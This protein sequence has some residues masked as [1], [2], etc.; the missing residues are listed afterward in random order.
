M[1]TNYINRDELGNDLFGDGKLRL[2]Q[3]EGRTRIYSVGPDGEWNRGE[4]IQPGDAELKGDL[5]VEV[6]IGRSDIHWLAEG[7][8]LDYLQGKHTARY[9]AKKGTHYAVQFPLPGWADE[10]LK[11]GPMTDG[12]RA[13]VELV[14]TNGEFVMGQPIEMRF[15]IRNEADH[16]IQIA[17]ES[18]RQGDEA[19]IEDKEGKP[20]S[21]GHNWYSGDS[22][23]Q[24]E[25]LKPG[26]TAVFKSS[27]LELLPAA[28]R[29]KAGEAKPPVGY[30]ARVAPG[31][32][33]VRF[34]LRFPG[35]TG[36]L[37]DWQGELETGPV[38]IDLKPTSESSL[39]PQTPGRESVAHSALAAFS[40]VKSTPDSP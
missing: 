26:Q 32:C 15:H 7:A 8:M 30:V 35:W 36:Q 34:R 17:S 27:S 13:A 20:V 40:A 24:R 25:V 9:L 33:T 14:T 11:F 31:K 19:I 38:V 3:K 39:V 6:E 28:E 5:G 21:M 29:G 4:L 1:Y 12:L 18:W 22:L 10:K 37:M 16:D 23:T 2:E